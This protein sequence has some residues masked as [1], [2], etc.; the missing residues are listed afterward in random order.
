VTVAKPEKKPTGADEASAGN[1]KTGLYIAG[2]VV[3]AAIV[4]GIFYVTGGGGAADPNAPKEDPDVATL[5]QEGPLEDIV[6]GNPDAPITIVEYASMT[7]PHCAR[8]HTDVFPTLKKKYVDT[9]KVRF[10]FREFPLDGLAVAASMLARCA[11]KD[12]YY[13]MVSGLFDTQKTWAVPGEEGKEKLL[14][15]AKQ[16]G[17]SK[18]QFDQCLAD[19]DLF[20][21]IV[22]VRKR[23]H[24]EFGVD[25]TPSF[26]ING[27]RMT[28]G[29]EIADFDA[30]LEHKDAADTPSG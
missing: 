2:A 21:K 15:I 20:D 13:P 26:F 7:C 18:E 6:I 27:K 3:A 4:G 29:H 9:G 14:L 11:G 5:M 28:G 30:V 12:R 19:K 24:E 22:A 1:S 16:A 17:F 25:S 23:A 8:F 10:V